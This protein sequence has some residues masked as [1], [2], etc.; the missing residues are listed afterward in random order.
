M[1]AIR[2]ALRVLGVPEP[3]PTSPRA[4]VKAAWPL[5][6]LQSGVWEIASAFPKLGK[7][8]MMSDETISKRTTQ[9]FYRIGATLWPDDGTYGDL[10]FSVEKERVM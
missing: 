9:M 8:R 10:H 7:V 2:E 1:A 3:W 4:I 6:L 5:E